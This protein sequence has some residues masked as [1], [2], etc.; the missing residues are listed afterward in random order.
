MRV[1][2]VKLTALPTLG[3]KMLH[4]IYAYY[5]CNLPTSR[6]FV[7]ENSLNGTSLAFVAYILY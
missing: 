6:I 2:M 3:N 4:F 7:A 1:Y 5:C